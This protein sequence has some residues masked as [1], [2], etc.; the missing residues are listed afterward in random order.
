MIDS[1]QASDLYAGLMSPAGLAWGV[2]SLVIS[3]IVMVRFAL[4]PGTNPSP[5]IVGWILRVAYCLY[6]TFIHTA[7]VDGFEQIAYNLSN[8]NFSDIMAAF[9]VN[10]DF[11]TWFCAVVYHVFGRSP[12]LLQAINIFFWVLTQAV[13]VRMVRESGGG[14]TSNQAAWIYA[15][16]PIAILYSTAIL[17]ESICIFGLVSGM[18]Y[19]LRAAHHSSLKSYG[20]CVIFF[21]LAALCHYGC[22]FLLAGLIVY[23]NVR[24][25]RSGKM[26]TRSILFRAGVLMATIGLVLGLFYGG[27]VSTIAPQFTPDELNLQ[28]AAGLGTGSLETVRTDYMSGLRTSSP[29][30][31]TWIIPLRM[32][33][34]VLA[35]LPWMVSSP[36]DALGILDSMFYLAVIITMFKYGKHIMRNYAISGAVFYCAM[37]MAIFAM[38]TASYGTA[39]RHRGKFFPVLIV[40]ACYAREAGQAAKN[41]SRR[42]AH[43]PSPWG[44]AARGPLQR[45]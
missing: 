23:P 40:I 9:G 28:E 17:R 6:N 33:Y 39:M 20:L 27:G 16:F 30:A 44:R 5:Y 10:A 15:L 45:N 32:I 34:F 13:L 43:S 14:K 24:W 35:P 11:Y 26:T 19:W 31:L 1:L 3:L 38:G 7:N 4:E 36:Y 37:G 41:E 8:G 25:Q 22:I 42:H 12:L 2:I 29:I 18:Y 21:L